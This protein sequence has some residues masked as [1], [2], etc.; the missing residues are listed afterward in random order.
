MNYSREILEETETLLEGVDN[1]PGE[2]M[3]VDRWE[4]FCNGLEFDD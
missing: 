2:G 3:A 1:S 4:K